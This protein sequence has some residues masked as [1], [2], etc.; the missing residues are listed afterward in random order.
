MKVVLIS[1]HAAD[2]DRKTGFHFWADILAKRNIDVDFITAGTS[3]LSFLKKGGKQLKPP[4]NQW[5]L[6]ARKIKKFTWLPLFHPLNLK[7]KFLNYLAWPLFA[8]YPRLLPQNMLDDV[9]DAD[10]FVV[11]SGAGVMLVPRLRALCPYAKFIYNFSDRSGVVKFHPIIEDSERRALHH[12]N[13]VRLNAAVVANDF[14]QGTPTR[15]IP[16]AIDKGLF[17]QPAPN[18]Y[19]APKNAISVGDMLFDAETVRM[20]AAHFPDWT[21]HPFG[22]GSKIGPPMSNVI[23]YGEMPFRQLVRYI[24]HAD[25]GLAPYANIAGTEYLSQSSL[26][27][28]QYTYCRLPIVAPAFAAKGRPHVMAYTHDEPD[29][30]IRAFESAMAL[31]RRTISSENVM[32]WEDVIDRMM[33]MSANS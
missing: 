24:R 27:L 13:M 19:A 20:L 32:G 8:L 30:V 15:Y 4:Y 29:S 16:Q 12:F 11:E 22:K 2:S 9:K 28:V 18:P 3:P 5:V 21:F 33:A 17:D 25:I 1:G 31:D 23:E 14:P 10:Y 6:I 26:K 7:N